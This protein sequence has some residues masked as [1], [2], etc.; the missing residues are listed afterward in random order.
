MKHGNSK[1]Q[2]SKDKTLRP[3]SFV[4]RPFPEDHSPL[5]CSDFFP[6][7]RRG[8]RRPGHFSAALAFMIVMLGTVAA[9]VW[10]IR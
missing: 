1:V 10:I 5:T 3:S 9:V 2:S 6:E 4:L 7:V 8:A